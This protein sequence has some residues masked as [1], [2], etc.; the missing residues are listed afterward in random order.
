[1]YV[2]I[3]IICTNFHTVLIKTITT[4]GLCACKKLPPF[5]FIKQTNILQI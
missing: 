5:D 3:S 1:M 2:V 4:H